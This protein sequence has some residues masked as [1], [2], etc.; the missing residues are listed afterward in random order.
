[1]RRR[2]FIAVSLAGG[3]AFAQPA[4]L[5]ELTLQQASERVRKKLVSPVEL[6]KAC[7]ERIGRLNPVLNAFITVTAEQALAQ[8]RELEAEQRR[9]SLRGPLHGI[10]VAVKD[11]I[12]VAGVRTTAASAVFANRVAEEDAG[13]VRRL[14]AEGA[15]LLGKL[16]MD[17][18]AYN[19]TSETSCFGPIHNPWALDRTPGGSSGGSAVAVAARLCFG[20]IGSDTGG[21]IRQ[22]AAFC[23]IA[24][25]KPS[26]GL[27]STRGALPL[28]W[29]LDHLGPMCRTVTDTAMLLQAIAGHDPE[30]PSSL[31]TPRTD[32]VAALGRRTSSLRL[33]VPRA[34]FY[35]DVDGEI[36]DAVEAALKVMGGM[37]AS[38]REVKLPEIGALPVLMAEAYAYH[39]PLLAQ[40]RELYH[41]LTLRNVMNGS[42]VS[43]PDYV[44]ARRRLDRIRLEVAG[45]FS[46]VDLLITPTTPRPPILLEKGRVPD[47]ILLRNAIPLNIYDLPTVSIPCGFT[48]AGLP[49]GLQISGPRLGEKTVLALAHAYEQAT[50]WRRRRPP[51]QAG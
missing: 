44:R 46:E 11:L 30:E 4:D 28:A 47:V 38:V 17:E 23:N 5:T 37:T 12:D 33:G 39:E 45:V 7:L 48:R 25:F 42:K 31:R 34:F 20:A 35:E 3:S 14:K 19:F 43:M 18:F 1:M 36:Q 27:V 2:D 9:G 13:V 24:G 51:I 50:Q 10:P 41:P 32:Y 6:T 26:Y 21:S 8:A 22:P 49:I 29:S 40:K 15:V 16:N